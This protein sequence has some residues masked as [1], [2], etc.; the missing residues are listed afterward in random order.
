MQ[1][2]EAARRIVE[3]SWRAIARAGI[4]KFRVT[5]VASDAGVSVGLV[6]YHFTDRNGLLQAT[7]DHA[8]RMTAIAGGIPDQDGRRSD[9]CGFDR[10]AEL[11]LADMS[12]TPT[13]RDNAVVWQE[14]MG[15][16]LF[17]AGIRDEV[18]A[19]LVDWQ[20]NVR[21]TI[22]DGQAVRSQRPRRQDAPVAFFGQ[23]GRAVFL[24]P[25]QMGDGAG[26]IQYLN[27]LPG[28]ES[29]DVAVVT[30]LPSNATFVSSSGATSADH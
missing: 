24:N 12:G 19:T 30:K 4:R 27:D 17:E 8:N 18:N 2:G 5:D 21:S 1:H 15:E 9:G 16:A 25:R 13:M 6:Y 28:H 10:L 22:A 11:L 26:W 23:P 14:L 20:E 7:M 29:A 3:A